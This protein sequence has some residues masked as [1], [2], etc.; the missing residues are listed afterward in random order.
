MEEDTL[1]LIECMSLCLHEEKG[2]YQQ[3]SVKTFGRRRVFG[4]QYVG[5][6]LSLLSTRILAAGPW[7]CLWERS[8]IIPRNW[9]QRKYWLQAFELL[10]TVLVSKLPILQIVSL[11]Y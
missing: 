3:A 2:R 5:D 7:A 8:A 9:N 4:I 11:I 1:K 10:L 6:K